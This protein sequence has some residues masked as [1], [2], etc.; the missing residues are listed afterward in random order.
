MALNDSIPSTAFDVLQKNMEVADE[1]VNSTSQ[2]A[3]NRPA[4]NGNTTTKTFYGMGVEFDFLLNQKDAQADAVIDDIQTRGDDAINNI[5]YTVGFKSVGLFSVPDSVDSNQETLTY[6]PPGEVGEEWAVEA[7]SYPYTPNTTSPY[8]DTAGGVWRNVT[9]EARKTVARS[10]N[11]KDSEVIYHDDTITPITKYIYDKSANQKTW[12]VPEVAQGKIIDT[13][14]G[15]QLTTTEPKTYQLVEVA[16]VNTA[17]TVNIPSD[18]LNLQDAINDL[19]TLPVKQGES[20]E[21][22]IE[23]GHAPSSGFSLSNGD[24]SKF[25]ISSVDAT[26]TADAAFAGVAVD[27]DNAVSPVWNFVLDLNGAGLGVAFNVNNTSRAKINPQCGII[28]GTNRGLHATN[29]SK[30][31]A[32]YCVFTGFQQAGVHS[33]RT[34][35]VQCSYADFSG[36]SLDPANNFGAVYASRTSRIHGAGI[37]ASNSGGDGVRA[38]RQAIVSVPGIDVS[39]ATKIALTAVSGARIYSENDSPIMTNLSG[40]GLVA[41]FGGY[42][43]I[44][45]TAITFATGMTSFAIESRNSQIICNGVSLSGH[46]GIGIY[47]KGT[48][49][50]IAAASSSITG[51]TS[52]AFVEEGAEA[53]LANSTIS[54]GTGNGVY[55]NEAARVCVTSA[56]VTGFSSNDLAIEKGSWISANGCTTTNGAGTPNRDDTNLGGA[57]GFNFLDNGT[58]GFIW[59]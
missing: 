48:G 7:S 52:G 27:L 9:L 21:L 37:N 41:Q 19:S 39:G 57:G 44:G 35:D 20:I 49:A 36:N 47:A 26:V 30:V 58:R 11:V 54:N 8:T 51:G 42:I 45:S 15:D 10:L 50:E 43:G 34:S 18:Y 4:P 28:N 2:T 46:E 22:L 25:V 3:T 33:S 6:A 5:T 12:L 56:S 53:N 29:A 17:I 55:A 13:V 24:Y 14:I 32:D 59:S 40:Q 1:V 23:S 31:V 16:N 38:Q